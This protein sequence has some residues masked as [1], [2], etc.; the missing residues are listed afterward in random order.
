MIGGNDIVFP[1]V[2]DSA[3][4]EA[5]ARIVRRWWPQVR[6]ED[7][8]TGDKYQRLDHVPF[9][10]VRELLAY[11]NADAEAAWDADSPDAAVNSMLYLVVRP[12]DITLVMDDPSTADMRSMLDAIRNYLWTD[13][14]LNYARAA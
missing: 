6:F 1:A 13:I 12:E 4:L 2:G 14:R 8:V 3:S 5:C 9:G 10:L 11:V 7:A